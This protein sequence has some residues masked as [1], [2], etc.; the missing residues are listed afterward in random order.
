[1]IDLTST[2]VWDAEEDCGKKFTFLIY[3]PARKAYYF[4]CKNHPQHQ[5]W[6]SAIKTV[7]ANLSK[8]EEDDYTSSDDDNIFNCCNPIAKAIKKKF[9]K[10]KK[11]KV[12]SDQ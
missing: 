1:V 9:T 11:D 4:A 5:A 7:R 3:H 6:L 8:Y 10:K 12:F 2:S